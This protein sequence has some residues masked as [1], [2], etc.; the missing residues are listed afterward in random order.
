[1]I[2]LS[3]AELVQHAWG[4][5]SNPSHHKTQTI[6]SNTQKTQTQFFIACQ[7]LMARLQRL[8]KSCT[9]TSVSS[10]SA[11]ASS[12]SSNWNKVLEEVTLN[13][14]KCFGIIKVGHENTQSTEV[15]PNRLRLAIF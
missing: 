3:G 6:N 5:D 1:M 13:I 4:P 7:K 12:D 2:R 11:E 10:Y 8:R 9:K 15:Q 14:G